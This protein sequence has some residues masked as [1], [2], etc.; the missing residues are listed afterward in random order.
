MEPFKLA[1]K[2]AYVTN[3]FNFKGR[4]N[5]WEYIYLTVFNSL[6]GFA[7]Q[8]IPVESLV[9]TIMALIV[10]LG[11]FIPTLACQVRRLHD[12]N[13][14]AWYLLLIPLSILIIPGIVLF[15]WLIIKSGDENTNNYGEAV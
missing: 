2:S 1:L 15:Y 11:I 3:R 9:V 14:S 8:I 13:K 12:I 7:F 4:A 6:L 5:R 10:M